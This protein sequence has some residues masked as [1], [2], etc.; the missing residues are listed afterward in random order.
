VTP[1]SDSTGEGEGGSV[2]PF[3]AALPSP[4]K[5]HPPLLRRLAT[6][7][8][9]LQRGLLDGVVQSGAALVE[10]PRTL[11]LGFRVLGF[12]VLGFE[13]TLFFDRAFIPVTGDGVRAVFASE[14]GPDAATC[15]HMWP[16]MGEL[17]RCMHGCAQWPSGA[18]DGMWPPAQPRHAR[19]G[20]RK[21]ACALACV[22][23]RAA[24]ACAT[25]PPN[26]LAVKLLGANGLLLTQGARHKYLRG[27]LTP[28]FS[29]EAVASYLPLIQELVSRHIGYM[30]AATADTGS[31]R[32]LDAFK[33]LSVEFILGVRHCC[34][35][36][37]T[38]PC[39]NSW[40]T[41][42]CP[43]CAAATHSSPPTPRLLPCS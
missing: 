25:H 21:H 2:C 15:Q 5:V 39:C 11:F 27:L 13:R 41:T 3:L 36:A 20:A 30:A 1:A 10:A 29:Y 43:A 24:C 18:G 12:R 34:S 22:P 26:T 40:R 7:T 9:T 8:E 28:A 33:L 32:G 17:M 4:P 23:P 16:P 37:P 14:F 19:T 38:M 42:P 31:A 35:G 6:D